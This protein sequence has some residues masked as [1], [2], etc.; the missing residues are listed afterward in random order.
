MY[1]LTALVLLLAAAATAMPGHKDRDTGAKVGGDCNLTAATPIKCNDDGVCS[2]ATGAGKCL[3]KRAKTGDPCNVTGVKCT[4]DTVCSTVAGATLNTCVAKH[5]GLGK[6]CGTADNILCKGDT[7]CSKT[8][9][10]NPGFC[11]SKKAKLG[12]KCDTVDNVKCKEGGVCATVGLA[13]GTCV[14]KHARLNEACSGADKIEC[15]GNTV[16][17][18]PPGAVQG[19]CVSKNGKA[20]DDCSIKGV[21]CKHDLTC[22]DVSKTCIALAGKDDKCGAVAGSDTIKCDE[23]LKCS[24]T[25]PTQTCV[26]NG[27]GKGDH[28]K[29]DKDH[30]DDDKDH[31]KDDKHHDKDDKPKYK[32]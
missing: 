29:D 20:G 30:D 12:D 8:G 25:A 2:V 26:K 10:I 6:A 4:G 14:S 16:C 13:I 28:D 18:K 7:V 15:I 9:G 32:H 1:P 22:G 3:A 17:S 11:V 27:K 23:G 5:V 21:K 31:D 19:T 24:G